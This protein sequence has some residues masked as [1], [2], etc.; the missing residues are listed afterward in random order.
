LSK[1][2]V[3]YKADLPTSQ[4]LAL[5]ENLV[6]SLK[7]GSV[8]VQ[9]DKEYVVMGLGKT[10]PMEVEV[11]ASQKKGKKRLSLELSWSD[12][13]QGAEQAPAIMIGT[14]APPAETPSPAPAPPAKPPAPAAKPPAPKPAKPPVPAPVVAPAAKRPAPKKETAAPKKAAKKITTRKKAASPKTK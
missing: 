4:A 14:Q 11:S 13:K 9:V 12:P 3:S 10:T 1:N 5:L 7:K 2:G 8:C 6:E